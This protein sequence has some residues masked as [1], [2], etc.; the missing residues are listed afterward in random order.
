MQTFVIVAGNVRTVVYVVNPCRIMSRCDVLSNMLILTAR[1]VTLVN[2]ARLLTRCAMRTRILWKHGCTPP[3]TNGKSSPRSL[4]LTLIT[5]VVQCCKCNML[6]CKLR[7]PRTLCLPSV[8]YNMP[9]L[10][11]LTLVR[12]VLLIG[13]QPLTMKLRTVQRIKLLLRLSKTGCV[14]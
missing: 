8:S 7:S 14:L 11:L 4:L 12:T 2:A 9:C 10:S 5:G 6:C 1:S 3:L 13:R